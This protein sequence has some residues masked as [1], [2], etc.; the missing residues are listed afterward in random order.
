MPSLMVFTMARNPERC[1]GA[2]R[3]LRER[4]LPPPIIYN[5]V[6]PREMRGRLR[7]GTSLP[8]NKKETC[9]SRISAGPVRDQD[10]ANIIRGGD[11]LIGVERS[12]NSFNEKSKNGK[13]EKRQGVRLGGS[14]GQPPRFSRDD[15]GS[16]DAFPLGGVFPLCPA[17]HAPAC[18]DTG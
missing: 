18:P 14:W 5:N 12:L 15:D 11:F 3:L 9:A 13:K 4:P 16:Y 8:H 17:R 10:K 7:G 1:R 6:S 2:K